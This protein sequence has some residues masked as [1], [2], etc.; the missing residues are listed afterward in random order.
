[1]FREA[2]ATSDL[3]KQ[4]GLERLLLPIESVGVGWERMAGP[5]S[6]LAELLGDWKKPW[7]GRAEPCRAV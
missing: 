1:M 7:H 2:S 5:A 6:G 3:S 4:L